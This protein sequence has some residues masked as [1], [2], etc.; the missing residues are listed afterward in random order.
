MLQRF[1]LYTLASLVVI[2]L[3]QFQFMHMCKPR[4]KHYSTY[5]GGLILPIRV[6]GT[7]PK[8]FTH[9]KIAW[10]SNMNLKVFNFHIFVELSLIT[11]KG[12]IERFLFGFGNWVT[13]LYGLMW[14]TQVISPHVHVCE[15]HMP[16][17]WIWLRDVA[18]IAHVMLE[19]LSAHV[20]WHWVMWSRWRR[21][22][23]D[24]ARQTSCKC[25]GQV[26]G[27]ETR[28]R[29]WRWSLSKTWHRWTDAR[30]K[31]KW[32]QD[33]WTNMITWWYEVDHIIVDRVGACVASTLEELE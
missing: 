12:K 8:S 24:L 21:S 5:I 26:G 25:E 15:Q 16:W 11:K 27:F 30:V 33:R 17:R 14:D 6:C 1:I 28:D 32:S 18:K 29:V 7:C 10:A 22:R 2:T 9:G 23:H 3:P 20:T 31:R 4:T 19:E 13:T